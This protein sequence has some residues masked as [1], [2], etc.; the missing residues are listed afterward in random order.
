MKK[1]NKKN[2]WG[3]LPCRML[4]LSR[5]K[6]CITYACF[7]VFLFVFLDFTI[8][9]STTEAQWASLKLLSATTNT[10]AKYF[11]LFNETQIAQFVSLENF[12]HLDSWICPSL[13]TRLAGS[14]FLSRMEGRMREEHHPLSSWEPTCLTLVVAAV[15]RN[16]CVLSVLA[17]C[18][19][20]QLGM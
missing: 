12:V 7:V 19:Q 1:K 11:C 4:I 10:Y 2:A 17:I 3:S 15:L 18:Y 9:I 5:S 13:G 6:L 16:M 8:F 20:T 14:N